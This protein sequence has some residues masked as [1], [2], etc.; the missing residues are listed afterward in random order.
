MFGHEKRTAQRY[1]ID[2]LF[3]DF[4]GVVHETVDISVRAVALVRRDG[5]D[6]STER[7]LSWFMS[8]NAAELTHSISQMSYVTTR[9][10]VVIF[11][12]IIRESRFDPREWE[13]ALRRHDV[14][15][16]IAPLEKMVG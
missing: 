8:S 9:D 1:V 7:G 14:R 16:G 12:Y 5:V 6:Y 13:R 2:G 4:N 15:A 3:V 10:A 11:D